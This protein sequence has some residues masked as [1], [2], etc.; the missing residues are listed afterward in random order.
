MQNHTNAIWNWR[1]GGPKVVEVPCILAGGNDLA[2]LA[3]A[4]ATGA[5]FVALSQAVLGADID[6][7]AACA[8]ANEILSSY[9][10]EDEAA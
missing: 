3:T 8:Q 7:K 9:V 4:A 1:I 6:A 5:D 10:F 2:S